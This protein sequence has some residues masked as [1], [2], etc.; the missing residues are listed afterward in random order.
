MHNPFEAELSFGKLEFQLNEVFHYP[1]SKIIAGEMP[2]VDLPDDLQVLIAADEVAPA[3]S[4]ALNLQK[5]GAARTELEVKS[6]RLRLLR[7]LTNSL[8]SN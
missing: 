7:E 8:A 6:A 4:H 1:I 5:S 3:V 2:K